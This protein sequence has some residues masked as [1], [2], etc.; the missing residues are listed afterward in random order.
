MSVLNL[1][2]QSHQLT[3]PHILEADIWQNLRRFLQESFPHETVFLISDENLVKIYREKISSELNDY[4]GF[5]GILS[6]PAGESSKSRKQKAKLEDQLLDLK[7]G[8]D[9]VILALGGGVTGDLVGY[10]TASL[11]RGISLIHLPTSLLA[12]VDSSIGGKVGI[13]HPAGKN[14]LGAFYQPKAVFID[15]GFLNSLPEIEYTN[16][17]AEVIKYAIILDNQLWEWIEKEQEKITIRN[18]EILYKIIERCVYLKIQ[19]VEKDETETHYR[20]VL[21]FGHTLGHAIEKLG[22]YEIKHGFAVAAG[23]IVAAKLSHHLLGYPK[24]NVSR[25]ID[26]L[27]NYHLIRVDVSRFDL[28]DLWQVMITDKKSRQQTPRF[29]L[30]KKTGAPSLFHPITKKELKSV[31][32]SH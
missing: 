17:L 24:E 8:R 21:N 29:T 30:L 28:D 26:L 4:P 1:S 25:L 7:A 6:F 27:K 5:R 13:N 11:H 20:S 9:T 32:K 18:L 14:L 15:P 22:K 10:V 16:G 12:M 31:L 19:V 3:I 23:M 2:I